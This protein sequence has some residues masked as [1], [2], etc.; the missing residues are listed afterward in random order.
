MKKYIVPAILVGIIM[1][2]QVMIL[3]FNSIH[4]E[5]SNMRGT[6]SSMEVQLHHQINDISTNVDQKLK[7]A[8][9]ILADVSYEIGNLDPATLL[10]D[11]TVHVIPKQTTQ[12]TIVSLV[13]MSD[14]SAK[15]MDRNGTQYTTVLS[16]PITAK[17]D[18]HVVIS[19]N[20]INQSEML[21][22]FPD[23]L[24]DSLPYLFVSANRSKSS[25]LFTQTTDVIGGE[26]TFEGHVIVETKP[27][28]NNKIENATLIISINNDVVHTQQIEVDSPE[29]KINFSTKLQPDQT[30]VMRVDAIDSFGLIHQSILESVTLNHKSEPSF[31]YGRGEVRVLNGQGEF[32]YS[33]YSGY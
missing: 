19:E 16:I 29:T 24:V 10:V 32:I 20:G 14:L 26:W 25:V 4:S 1:I 13:G 27:A 30:L 5:I 12:R 22:S 2:Q 33:N 3:Q 9:S 21:E 17:P 7:K 18:L 23:L 15:V 31:D 11:V 8:A 28:Q 6:I